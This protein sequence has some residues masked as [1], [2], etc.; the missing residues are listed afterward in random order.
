MKAYTKDILYLELSS[1]EAKQL[2]KELLSIEK[3]QNVSIIPVLEDL[4][5]S[6]LETVNQTSKS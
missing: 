4:L 6:Y 1:E 5:K 2:R 3:M